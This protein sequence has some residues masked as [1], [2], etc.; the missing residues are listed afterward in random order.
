VE[1]DGAVGTALP[2]T[3]L[4]LEEAIL[5]MEAML[6]KKQPGKAATLKIAY[7]YML[8]KIK[9]TETNRY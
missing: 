8:K 2:G 5:E 1:Q 7:N 3:P 9:E 4:S 6:G